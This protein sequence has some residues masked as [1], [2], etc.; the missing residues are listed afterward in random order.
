[1]LLTAIFNNID[2]S[3][4][5]A[6]E[7]CPSLFNL[8]VNDEEKSDLVLAPDCHH[9]ED[10]GWDEGQREEDDE[11]L[12]N[13]SSGRVSCR[14]SLSHNFFLDVVNGASLVRMR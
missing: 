14:V 4:R 6:R 7:K 2:M 3:E 11:G 8:I 10:H 1:L 5:L 9:D 13:A 12:A